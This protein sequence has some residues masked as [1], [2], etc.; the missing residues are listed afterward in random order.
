MRETKTW[1]IDKIS[2]NLEIQDNKF[3]DSNGPKKNIYIYRMVADLVVWTM[4]RVSS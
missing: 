2:E 1:K 3:F 4:V